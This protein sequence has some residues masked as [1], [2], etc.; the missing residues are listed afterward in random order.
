MTSGNI[1][2]LRTKNNDFLRQTLRYGIIGGLIGIGLHIIS[3]IFSQSSGMS[4]SLAPIVI[5]LLIGFLRYVVVSIV[6][7]VRAVRQHRDTDMGGY[8]SRER[9]I[10][11]S[12]TIIMIIHTIYLLW[13]IV[14]HKF[15]ESGMFSDF[16]LLVYTKYAFKYVLIFGILMSLII[17][18]VM[19]K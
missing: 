1:N 7:I 15:L 16:D 6:M 10:I 18:K 17:S 3:Y 2:N 4:R 11:M 9:C 5:L 13:Y 19:T 14:L 8:I 12:M